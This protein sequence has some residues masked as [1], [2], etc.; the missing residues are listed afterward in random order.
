MRLWI[1][2]TALLIT[3][4]VGWLNDAGGKLTH[5]FKNGQ[6]YIWCCLTVVLEL[7]QFID[8][9]HVIEKETDILYWGLILHSCLCK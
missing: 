2:V 7:L 5:L 9:E 6:Y 4:L 1:I 8:A 3:D